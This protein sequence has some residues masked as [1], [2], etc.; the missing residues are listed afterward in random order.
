MPANSNNADAGQNT[1]AVNISSPPQAPVFTPKDTELYF[2]KLELFFEHCK[3]DSQNKK[4]MT[5]VSVIN[6]CSLS[7]IIKGVLNKAS[8]LTNPYD[9]LKSKILA[10]TTLTQ[11]EK[12]DIFLKTSSLGDMTPSRFL[13]YLQGLCDSND[14][15]SAIVKSKFLNA[16]SSDTRSILATMPSASLSELAKTADR[17]YTTRLHPPVSINKISDEFLNTDDLTSFLRKELKLLHQTLAKQGEEISTLKS[18][19]NDRV[20]KPTNDADISLCFY[21]KKFGINARK[22]NPSC[23]KYG[24]KTVLN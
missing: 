2:L 14:G 8:E 9:E 11:E 20:S 12:L 16:L 21:H 3:I 17:I 6:D 4:L 18:Y 23:S 15:N 7:S 10:V 1:S 13:E 24:G 5:L 22:C 19:V